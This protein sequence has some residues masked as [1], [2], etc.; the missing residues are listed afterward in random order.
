MLSHDLRSSGRG[1]HST[2]HYTIRNGQLPCSPAGSRS[3]SCLDELFRDALA[4]LD[5][6]CVVCELILSF[7]ASL[8][9]TGKAV[10]ARNHSP[11][12]INTYPFWAPRFWHGM[13]L[14]DWV[15]LLIRNRFRIHPL[16]WG[17]AFTV[18]S[19]TIFNTVMSWIQQLFYGRAIENTDTNQNLVF[20][21]G[22][23]RSGTTLLHELLVLDDR[24]AYPTT[25]ECF[26]PNHFLMTGKW[27]PKLIWF[28]L[29]RKRPMD[30]MAV[31][32]DHPQEDEFAL[33]GMGAPSPLLR[34]AFPNDPP[35]YMEFLDM[36]GV[37]A[38]DLEKWKD[39]L[40]QFVAMQLIRK[41][42]ALVLKSPTHTGRL[43]VLAEMFP[44]AKFVHITR[45]PSQLFSSTQR[46]WTALDEAQGFQLPREE[47]LDEYVF[48]ALERMYRGFTQQRPTIDPARICD[49]QFEQLIRNPVESLRRIYEQ[50][51]LGDFEPVRP[52]IEAVDAATQEPQRQS[53]RTSTGN[54]SRNR[55][56]LGRLLRNV[57]I[58]HAFVSRR[59]PC[60]D[61]RIQDSGRSRMNPSVPNASIIESA[62]C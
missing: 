1:R 21:L 50:L 36:E 61:A 54:S 12:Q 44:N 56:A 49:I 15:R 4:P 8:F 47:R 60:G 37:R 26:A 7:L 45:D 17:L 19:V 34:M 43:Q 46:L 16:R 28:L 27:M 25:Y 40:R 51:G 42:K 39:R 6:G 48:T 53:A 52:K 18:T 31:S 5:A 24:F 2:V 22:H 35:P 3:E 33:I 55:S 41:G 32:F 13:V 11:K 57:R 30:D 20:I 9:R 23:W 59:E 58:F 10:P 38:E 62:T 14:T 29:P